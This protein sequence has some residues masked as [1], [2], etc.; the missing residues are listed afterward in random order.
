VATQHMMVG[1]ATFELSGRLLLG[2]PT[3][4]QQL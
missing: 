1:D 2:V 3:A 4:T